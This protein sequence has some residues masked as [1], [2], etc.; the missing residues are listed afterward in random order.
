MNA[1]LIIPAL[2]EAAAIGD[3]VRRV[4]EGGDAPPVRG[5][6]GLDGQRPEIVQDVFVF[7]VQAVLA[8]PEIYR[9]HGKTPT[10][11]L[12][13]GTREAVD[14][15]VGSVAVGAA[16]VALVGETNPERE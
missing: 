2:D 7:R 10:D 6:A 1:T 8:N 11:P 14:D 12:D 4:R 15:G 16:Q 9:P 3:L 13:V 5:D